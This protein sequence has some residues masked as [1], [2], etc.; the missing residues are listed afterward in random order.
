MLYKKNV[1]DIKKN[2]VKLTL[3][4]AKNEIKEVTDRRGEAWIL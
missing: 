3:E 4:A 1:S 2:K